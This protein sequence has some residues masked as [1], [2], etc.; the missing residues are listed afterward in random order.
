MIRSVEPN[1]YTSIAKI[2]KH[3]ILTSI[4]TFEEEV[5]SEGE[6][7]KR[8]LAKTKT[9]PWFVYE[10]DNQILGYA[11]AGTWNPRAAYKQTAEVSI[12]LSETAV[13]KGVGSK[14][15]R[16][17]IDLLKEQGYHTLIGGI[18]LPNEASVNLHEKFGFEKVAHFKSV[19]YKFN[20]WIDVGYWQL[21]LS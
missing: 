21:M 1:D 4:A 9:Y 18:S 10:D 14:L 15:Y 2:Y 16:A 17:L 11:Y 20:K 19:G 5:I 7:Q 8:I 6:M 3:Y 12:Y 13:G